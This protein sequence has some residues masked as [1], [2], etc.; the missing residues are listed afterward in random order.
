MQ[1]RLFAEFCSS[2]LQAA[3]ER[4]VH[5][6]AKLDSTLVGAKEVASS[7]T[8]TA[9]AGIVKFVGELMRQD[10]KLTILKTLQ[11]EPI[12]MSMKPD[13]DSSTQEHAVCGMQWTSQL[14]VQQN[15]ILVR[16]CLSQTL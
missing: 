8:A 9:I 10:K 2:L 7:D 1:E 15:K 14:P 16:N 3:H 13:I 5:V 12:G 4:H 11:V 6:Q